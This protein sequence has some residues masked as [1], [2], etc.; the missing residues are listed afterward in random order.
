MSFGDWASESALRIRSKGVRAGTK[1][2]AEQLLVGG[3]RRLGGIAP[4]GTNVYDREWD[5]LVILDA[6]RYDLVREVADEYEY[7]GDVNSIWS[8]GS[9]SAEWVSNTFDGTHRNAVNETTYVSGNPHTTAKNLDVES[10]GALENVWH[11]GVDSETGTVL[12]ETLTDVAIHQSRTNNPPR[13]IVHYM[14]P[15]WPFIPEPISDREFLGDDEEGGDPWERLRL[16]EVERGAV[17]RSYRENLRYVL[18]YLPVLLEN[19]DAE[20]VAITADHRNGL[21]EF[22]VFG[23]PSQVLTPE[24]RKVPWSETTAM[25]KKTRKPELCQYNRSDSDVGTDR[26]ELLENLGYL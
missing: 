22:G 14:Q 19:V 1:R 25:D 6:A 20:R 10:L 18:D 8:V 26:E 3:L 2:S 11:Y 16:G 9:W 7:L 5:L 15:H 17:W 23:H 12:P 21:G 24:L 13:M 4:V